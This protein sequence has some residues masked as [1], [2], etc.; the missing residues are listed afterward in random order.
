M[1]LFITKNGLLDT[2]QD[3]GRYGF[4][5]LGINPGGAMDCIAMRLVNILVGNHPF[6]PVLEMHF[7]AAEI[8]VESPMLIALGG[9]DFTA[10]INGNE[11]PLLHPVLVQKKSI[12]K[13]IRRK[14]GAR[15]YLSVQGGISAQ[16]WLNSASTDLKTHAGG[17]EGRALK[18]NDRLFCKET[19]RSGMAK[20]GN[21]FVLFPWEA[22]SGKLYRKNSFRFIPGFEFGFLPG[23]TKKIML[24][25]NF[26]ISSLSDRMGYRLEGEPLLLARPINLLSSAVTRG[27]IQLLPNGQLIILM[28]DHQTTGGYPRVGH[29]ISTD[30]S[31]LAQLSAGDEFALEAVDIN[32]AEEAMRQQEIDL[33][34]IQNACNFRLNDFFHLE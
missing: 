20:E 33:Q 9:A 6:E 15:I 17:F 8:L 7:P 22:N 4:Q 12:L 13:F 26:S 19:T 24:S 14:K 34:Q 11:I 1:S 16:K 5:E 29:I 18:K 30:F 23:E 2:L 27:T 25:T 3:G 31:S 28:A 32:I 21:D 10:V